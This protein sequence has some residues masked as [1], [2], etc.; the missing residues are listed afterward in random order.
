MSGYFEALE[1]HNEAH[2]P[3]TKQ[4]PGQPAD[5]DRLRRF[6]AARKGEG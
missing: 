2:S 3:D 5:I 6:K 1:A 4:E